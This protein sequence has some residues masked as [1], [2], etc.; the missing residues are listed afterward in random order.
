MLTEQRTD[1]DNAK[2]KMKVE[3]NI[4]K[5]SQPVSFDKSYASLSGGNSIRH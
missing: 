1:K 4:K 3:Q 2:R 5:A